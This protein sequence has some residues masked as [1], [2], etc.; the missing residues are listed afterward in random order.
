LSKETY[1][2]KGTVPVTV[3]TI[4]QHPYTLAATFG[5]NANLY[6]YNTIKYNIRRACIAFNEDY[7]ANN[8]IET[9]QTEWRM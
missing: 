1:R 4:W 3:H 9:T 7:A 2:Y 5:L 8:S 6:F